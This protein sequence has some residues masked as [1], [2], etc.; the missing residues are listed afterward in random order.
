MDTRQTQKGVGF[1]VLD[2]QA[3]SAALISGM[4]AEWAA[5]HD[6]LTQHN[7]NPKALR[8]STESND[9]ESE[10]VGKAEAIPEGGSLQSKEA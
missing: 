6:A 7:T 5:E 1:H 4:S 8:E 2:L 9:G 10:A 3:G